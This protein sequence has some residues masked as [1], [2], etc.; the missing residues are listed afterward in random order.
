MAALAQQDR[1]IW[2]LDS[3]GQG[4]ELPHLAN[5][6]DGSAARPVPDVRA[7]NDDQ[8][9]TNAHGPL[10][11]Q[12]M[13]RASLAFFAS[14][15]ISGDP[16]LGG[17]FFCAEH[18]EEWARQIQTNEQV[19]IQAPRDHGKSH[20]LTVA[21]T[22]WE[23]WRRP[24]CE[25]VIFS[26][27]QP[28][29]EDQLAKI[30]REIENNP[31]L[32]HLQDS[33]MWSST[34]I[35][36]STGSVI[37]A[38]GF[39]VKSRGM[40][41]HLIVC[42]DVVSEAAMYSALVR[43]R[44]ANFF[45]A[46]VR[47]MLVPG[48]KLVVVGTPQHIDDLY[49]QL[50][51]NPRWTFRRYQAANDDWTVFLWPERYNEQ[52]LAERKEEIGQ[53]RFAREFMCSPVASGASLFPEDLISGE[54]FFAFHAPFGEKLDDGSLARK[55]WLTRGVKRFY[56]GVDIATSKNVGADWFVIFIV[57]LDERGNRWFVDIFREQGMAYKAQKAQIAHK[58]K[59]WRADMVCIEGNAAQSIYGA[60]LRED[61]DIPVM[62]HHTGVEKHDLAKGIPGLVVLFEN[63][64]YRCPRSTDDIIVVT[65]AWLGELAAWTFH[66]GKVL[67]VA[68][69][70]DIAMAHWL[71]ELAIQ[72]GEAFSFSF[73][74]QPG[75]KEA[76]EELEA[77]EAA[78]GDGWQD[79]P[80]VSLGIE[81][82]D[83]QGPSPRADLDLMG[84]GGAEEGMAARPQ[85][86]LGGVPSFA[87]AML[88]KLINGGKS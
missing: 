88:H 33:T 52:L 75:D 72:R 41:P 4:T 68:R 51:R 36:L 34:K 6:I 15:V 39:G 49:A 61:T 47:N 74:E 9:K 37:Y 25:I 22:I 35:R 48:G 46:A 50:E 27:T 20:M 43:E 29:A 59:V 81:A 18:H 8:L 69:H 32:Q 86:P 17:T 82:N 30:K 1:P 65:D 23:A 58:A 73:D 62:L 79:D 28:Q 87:P 85:H 70:D 10:L 42:D 16:N 44:Q 56:L 13:M 31:R 66:D 14:E 60:E 26:E 63:G 53:I 3:S 19:C 7:D 45:F 71:C 5:D 2:W 24:G 67:S 54:P 12:R 83:M 64:K 55:W 76:A 77:E 38:R 11:V 21:L 57:G 84:M 40:H 80:W 78:I